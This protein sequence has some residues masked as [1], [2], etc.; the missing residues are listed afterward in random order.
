M[1]CDMAQCPGFE[2][3]AQQGD[4]RYELPFDNTATSVYSFTAHA[5]GVACLSAYH[6]Q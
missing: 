3:F 6:R 4:I 2:D 1:C 5:L